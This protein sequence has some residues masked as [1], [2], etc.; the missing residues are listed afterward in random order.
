MAFDSN[1]ELVIKVD[2]SG[3]N[4][5]ITAVNRG[6]AGMGTTANTA[7]QTASRGMD[8]MVSSA[9]LLQRSIRNLFAI[10]MVVGYADRFLSLVGKMQKVLFDWDTSMH[11]VGKAASEMWQKILNPEIDYGAQKKAIAELKKVQDAMAA[12]SRK[13]TAALGRETALAGLTGPARI[14]MVANQAIDELRKRSAAGPGNIGLDPGLRTTEYRAIVAKYNKEMAVQQVADAKK[15]AEELAKVTEKSNAAIQKGRE[16]SWAGAQDAIK[17][18]AEEKDFRLGLLQDRLKAE[19]DALSDL[20]KL[21]REAA[22]ARLDPYQKMIQEMAYEDEDRVAHLRKLFD[23]GLIG[24]PQ[25]QASIEQLAVVSGANVEKVLRDQAEEVRSEQMRIFESLKSQ[26]GGVFDAL[27]T[28]SSSVF[29]AIG[30]VFKVAILT[31]IK[32]IVTSRVAGM[33]MQMFTGTRVSFA[34]GGMG[35]LGVL[36]GMAPIFGAGSIMGGLGGTGGFTGPVGGAGGGGFGG[37]AGLAGMGSSLKS[38]FGIGA[39]SVP[40]GGIGPVMPSFGQLGLGGKLSSIAGS[41]AAMMGGGL[42]AMA[43]LQRGGLSGLGMSTAGGTLLGFGIGGPLGAGIGA[44]IGGVA[45]LIRMMFK[46]AAEKLREKI[47][48]AYGVDMKDKSALNQILDMA[49]SGFGGN[50]DMAIRSP[51]IRDLIELYAMSTGQKSSGIPAAM[52]PISL[53][54]SGG[55]VFSVGSGGSLDRIGAGIASGGSPQTVS[56]PVSLTLDGQVLDSRTLNVVSKNG[57][58]V[59]AAVTSGQKAS[60][61]RREQMALQL[62]P[63]LLTS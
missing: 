32:E 60:S 21:E 47:R 39:G 2:A 59:S 19:G 37:F 46:G 22:V 57:R 50:L 10:G 29:A 6:L 16:L 49:K 28:K 17:A 20:V 40:A 62:N 44:A 41:P 30:N 33:L 31:A 8:G 18:M 35:T 38:L 55:S 63:G 36:G 23:E 3:A 5:E 14:G 7:A 56:V 27:L 25:L 12:E 15:A 61:G 34:G 1:L 13:N 24:A 4:A 43:G 42:L 9:K 48:A 54:Q 45:G 26:A 11:G 51:Q 53:L 52:K 58:I